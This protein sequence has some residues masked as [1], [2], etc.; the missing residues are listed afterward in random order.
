MDVSLKKMPLTQKLEKV[1]N[2]LIL[3]YV[4]WSKEAKTTLLSSCGQLVMK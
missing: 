3:T 1:K 2:G 4:P